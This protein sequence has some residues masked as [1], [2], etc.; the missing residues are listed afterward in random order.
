MER[1]SWGNC[2]AGLAVMEEVT[3]M[4]DT[5]TDTMSG[6]AGERLTGSFVG[7]MKIVIGLILDCIAKTMS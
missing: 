3:A 4:E 2:R 7:G 6:I 1:T 5:A